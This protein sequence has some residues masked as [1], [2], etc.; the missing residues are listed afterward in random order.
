VPKP[1][2]W[3]PLLAAASLVAAATATAATPGLWENK[4]GSV[5]VEVTSSGKRIA[6]ITLDCNRNKSVDHIFR[7]GTGPRIRGHSFSFSG[8]GRV[9]KGGVPAGHLP[10][11]IQASFV[12]SKKLTGTIS[13]KKCRT[14]N[15]SAKPTPRQGLQLR[16]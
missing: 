11:S 2:R 10:I 12:S 4:S 16:R 14:V 1:R 7:K 13:A 3:I 8:R 9:V 6:S 15:F 5:V